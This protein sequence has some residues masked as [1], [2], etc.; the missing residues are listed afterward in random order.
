MTG[1]LWV[2][3]I[4]TI[5][6]GMLLQWV[7]PIERFLAAT[8]SLAGLPERIEAG[9]TSAAAEWGLGLEGTVLVVAAAALAWLLYAQ[10]AVA[11]SRGRPDAG[12]RALCPFGAGSSSSTGSMG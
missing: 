2:L 6:V 8:P 10:P 12:H 1:P 4:G 9:S 3:A 11:A 5:V 7:W